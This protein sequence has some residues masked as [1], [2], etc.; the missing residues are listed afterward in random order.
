MTP[1]ADSCL[2]SAAILAYQIQ[3]WLFCPHGP[4]HTVAKISPNIHPKGDRSYLC[5]KFENRT[6]YGVEREKH[7]AFA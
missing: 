5:D 7:N 4:T 1:N 6:D 2:K 3:I